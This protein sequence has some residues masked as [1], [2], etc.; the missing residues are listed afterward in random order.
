M[1]ANAS[2]QRQRLSVEVP[3]EDATKR[4]FAVAVVA[5][6]V[7]VVVV[8]PVALADAGESAKAKKHGWRVFAAHGAVTELDADSD[9][10][11]CG[12]PEGHA[13]CGVDLFC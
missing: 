2:R 8:A 1:P 5:A 13:A 7:V 4:L 10:F 6:V 11:S 3:A 12:W 9:C